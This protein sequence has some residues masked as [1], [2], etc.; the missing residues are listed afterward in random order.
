M[1][2]DLILD[3]ESAGDMSQ[4]AEVDAVDNNLVALCED[5]LLKKL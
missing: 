3:N 4:R 5:S 1:E 2:S